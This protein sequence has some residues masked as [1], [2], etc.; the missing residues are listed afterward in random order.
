[1]ITAERDVDG[2]LQGFLKI[3]RDLSERRQAAEVLRQSE[4]RLRLL[5]DGVRDYAIF[6]LGPDGRITTWNAGAAGRYQRC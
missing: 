6:A 4:E 2:T 1:M 3:T 5:V